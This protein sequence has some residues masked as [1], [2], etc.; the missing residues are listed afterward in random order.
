MLFFYFWIINSIKACNFVSSRNSMSIYQA[1]PDQ[2]P[3]APHSLQLMEKILDSVLRLNFR[4][5]RRKGN[6]FFLYCFLLNLYL[7]WYLF[8]VN[9]L[10]KS[11]LYVF[12]HVFIFLIFTLFYR[13]GT[14]DSAQ[15]FS[16]RNIE[17]SAMWFI[18]I[19][20]T[21]LNYYVW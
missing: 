19:M 3:E 11:C 12:V 2:S 7:L 1:K 13:G 14:F 20:R 5:L 9:I 15:G 16:L 4:L 10:V 6:Y 17:L 18:I 8:W 21:F